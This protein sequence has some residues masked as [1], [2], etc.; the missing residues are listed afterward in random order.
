MRAKC[1]GQKNWGKHMCLHGCHRNKPF[2]T[3]KPTKCTGWFEKADGSKCWQ[4][5][6]A[7]VWGEGRRSQTNARGALRRT[8]TT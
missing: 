5:L 1:F 8:P 4:L 6:G 2:P 3:S 7:S